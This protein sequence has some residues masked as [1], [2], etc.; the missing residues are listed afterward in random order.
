LQQIRGEQISWQNLKI[1]PFLQS[2]NPRSGTTLD[3]EKIS[4]PI[5]IEESKR[6]AIR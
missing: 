3:R 2:E 1:K 6:T 4:A 5:K